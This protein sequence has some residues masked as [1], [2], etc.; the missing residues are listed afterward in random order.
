M[1][2]SQC[3]VSLIPLGSQESLLEKSIHISVN[4]YNFADKKKYYLGK[5]NDKEPTQINDLK[6]LA[7]AKKDFTEKDIEIRTEKIINSFIDF[8]K[9]EDLIV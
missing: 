3:T 6:N 2:L 4:A 1:A 7:N 9:Q 5:I 8:L